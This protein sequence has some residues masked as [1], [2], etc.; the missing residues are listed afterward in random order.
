MPLFPAVVPFTAIGLDAS[1]SFLVL[2]LVFIMVFAVLLKL[3][4]LLLRTVVVV[5]KLAVQIVLAGAKEQNL[6]LP[7]SWVLLRQRLRWRGACLELV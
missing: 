7:A 4:A 3:A 5:L 1:L 6:L 2:V